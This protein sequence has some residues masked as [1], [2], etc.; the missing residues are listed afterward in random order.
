MLLGTVTACRSRI[1]AA[2][3]TCPIE[4]IRSTTEEPVAPVERRVDSGPSHRRPGSVLEYVVC[5]YFANVY[6][7]STE[8]PLAVS[9]RTQQ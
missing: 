3:P 5:N 8:A 6:I 1:L 9:I 2:S 7:P 4:R